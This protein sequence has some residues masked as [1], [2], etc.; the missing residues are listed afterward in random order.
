MIHIRHDERQMI[1]HM[2]EVMDDRMSDQPTEYTDADTRAVLHAD[3]IGK[4]ETGQLVISGA[5][6]LDADARRLMRQIIEA[7]LK[8]WVPNASQRLLWRASW[9]LNVPLNLGVP[10]KPDC[11][12]E[13]GWH[14]LTGSWVAGLFVRHCVTC[15][16][17]FADGT[18]EPELVGM[19]VDDET[20]CVDKDGNEYPEHCED[21]YNECR[22]CGAEL[23]Y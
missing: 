6:M 15:H 1:R 3:V 16:R 8:A 20:V 23:D 12:A 2:A 5:E 10:V 11:G 4:A 19:E 22:R 13:P 9:A 17:L 21:S 7:E 18:P 14:A